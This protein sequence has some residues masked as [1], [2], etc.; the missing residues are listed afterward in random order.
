MISQQLQMLT[1]AERLTIGG[2]FF[3]PVINDVAESLQR[4]TFSTHV[5]AIAP[6]STTQDKRGRSGAH[7][8]RVEKLASASTARVFARLDLLPQDAPI[9][10]TVL[11]DLRTTSSSP[12]TRFCRRTGLE[13]LGCT[14]GGA[15]RRQGAFAPKNGRRNSSYLETGIEVRTRG[16]SR[17]GGGRDGVGEPVGDEARWR[18]RRR[19]RR[20]RWPGH[21][22]LPDRTRTR[23][24]SEVKST[25]TR[26]EERRIV[27]RVAATGGTFP[28]REKRAARSSPPKEGGDGSV[29]RGWGST[30]S[31]VGRGKEEKRF[32]GVAPADHSA[33]KRMGRP[34]GGGQSKSWWWWKAA[35]RAGTQARGRTIRTS[36]ETG[37]RPGP[38]ERNRLRTRSGT[39]TGAG[40]GA[41]AGE[42]PVRST[43]A[44]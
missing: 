44:T 2:E 7:R 27:E 35:A 41:G 13:A 5:S 28:P 24:G 10:R 39:R 22:V 19:S 6:Q 31:S 21:G 23:A 43:A 30:T 25:M 29:L 17:R 34:P 11:V 14:R 18:T 1:L 9:R 40:A 32:R 4:R 42:A 15:K 20:R 16:R 37:T 8:L 33:Q 26:L 38:P 12:V 36:R 3:S